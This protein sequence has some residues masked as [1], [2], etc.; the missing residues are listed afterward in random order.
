LDR[1]EAVALLKELGIEHLIQPT[2]V[3]IKQRTPDSYQLEIKGDYDLKE[4]E[5]LLKNRKFCL[6]EK[7]DYLIIFKL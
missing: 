5:R 4:I 2:F 3:L 7:K 1:K 6:E